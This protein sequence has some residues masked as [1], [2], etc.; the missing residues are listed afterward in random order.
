MNSVNEEEEEVIQICTTQYIAKIMSSY[1]HH[2]VFLI[3]FSVI[4]TIFP[5]VPGKAWSLFFD[6]LSDQ[7]KAP[8]DYS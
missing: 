3:S 6:P 7:I 2:E 8:F 4:Q 5:T 1:L